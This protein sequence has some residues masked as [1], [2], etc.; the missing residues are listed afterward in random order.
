MGE[1]HHGEA[2]Y[3]QKDDKQRRGRSKHRDCDDKGQK[4]ASRSRSKSRGKKSVQ[5]HF[6]DKY[7]HIKKDCHAWKKAKGKQHKNSSDDEETHS[8]HEKSV[9]IQEINL[10]ADATNDA[11][12]INAVTETFDV[13]YDA[14][15]TLSLDSKLSTEVLVSGKISH[16]WILDSGAS[17]HVTPHRDWFT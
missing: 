8:K 7:G 2:H 3:V 11:Q 12:E 9:K 13:Y 16:T 17:L 1:S 10:V 6:C 15:D 5:C 14:M 4:D